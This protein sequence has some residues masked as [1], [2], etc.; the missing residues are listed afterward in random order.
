MLEIAERFNKATFSDPIAE[1]FFY[2]IL[3]IFLIALAFLVVPA[4]RQSRFV[5]SAAAIMTTVGVLGTFW[6][7]FIGLLDFDVENID[8]SIGP[9]LRGLRIAFSTSIA[10]MS[11]ALLFKLIQTVTPQVRAQADSEAQA[12]RYLLG[13]IRDDAKQTQAAQLQALGELRAAIS[14]DGDASVVTQLQKT[15]TELKDKQDELITEFRAFAQKMNEMATGALIDA[16]RD[17][18]R[19]FN[20]K[21]TEQFGEN[22]KQLNSAVGN[23]VEWQAQYRVHVEGLQERLSRAVQVVEASEQA[24]AKIREHSEKIPPAVDKLGPVLTGI[25]NQATDLQGHLMALSDL[26]S[27]ALEAFPIIDQNLKSMTDELGQ[28]VIKAIQNSEAILEGQKNGMQV[29]TAGFEGLSTQAA[30]AQHIFQAGLER[31]MTAMQ[32]DLN[33][34][35]TKYEGVIDQT[36]KEV[37]EHVTA[38]LSD[39][40]K[41]MSDDFKQFD[42]QMQKEMEQAI[43][44]MGRQLASLSEK[45]VEDYKPLTDRLRDLMQATRVS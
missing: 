26:R 20:Q 10:G 24:L 27:Q 36:T 22:F 35:L 39:G 3:A 8:A 19:D 2:F 34:A 21:L 12:I 5:R 16:L 45:F 30:E 37:S 42:E 9:L 40:A 32:R 31:A 18:I 4:T 15:R 44:A 38:A 29:L 11:A 23:L 7:I 25:E 6:G 28:A 17:V 1:A 33:E 14:S 13:E 43:R 41:K